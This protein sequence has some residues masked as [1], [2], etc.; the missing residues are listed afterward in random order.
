[1]GEQNLGIEVL[2]I[3]FYLC[4]GSRLRKTLPE[5]V[6]VLERRLQALFVKVLFASLAWYVTNINVEISESR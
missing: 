3:F 1:M 2:E 5:I 6:F 4:V